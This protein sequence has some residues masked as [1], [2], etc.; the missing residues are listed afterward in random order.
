[1]WGTILPW[2]G[3]C[4]W[5]L[6]ILVLVDVSVHWHECALMWVY[7]WTVIFTWRCGST[8][9]AVLTPECILGIFLE[10][11][12][13]PQAML[14]TNS[15]QGED[16]FFL[17]LKVNLSSECYFTCVLVSV[18]EGY[19]PKSG[20]LGQRVPYICNFI[21]HLAIII[22]LRSSCV[23]QAGLQVTIL[24]PRPRSFGFTWLHGMWLLYVPFGSLRKYI[25]L[26]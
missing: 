12:S 18:S 21:I 25:M 3:H 20:V 17:I 5:F 24:L 4:E 1:M 16:G 11:Y 10:L 9:L 13:K 2:S 15:F 26:R 7:T 8:S 23:S 22:I 19:I 6:A 14:L